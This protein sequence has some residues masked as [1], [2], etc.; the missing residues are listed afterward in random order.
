MSYQLR[1]RICL[2][3]DLALKLRASLRVGRQRT[4]GAI[5]LGLEF[6]WR[7]GPC[8]TLTTELQRLELLF[9][10]R[11]KQFDVLL[12][13]LSNIL[14]LLGDL[15]FSFGEGGLRGSQDT[16]TTVPPADNIRRIIPLLHQAR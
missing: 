9:E 10:S 2:S 1:L 4:L 11:L 7:E 14:P 16:L 6:L 5:Y 13:C 15:G 12:L 8:R 3:P